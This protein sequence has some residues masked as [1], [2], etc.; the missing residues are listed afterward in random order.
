MDSDTKNIIKK[1]WSYNIFYLVGY[2]IFLIASV[3]SYITK[4]GL[5]ALIN[6]VIALIFLIIFAVNIGLAKK[7]I[8]NYRE[9]LKKHFEEVIQIKDSPQSIAL[10]F[11]IGTTIAVLPTFG[12]GPL[13]GL[14]MILI[15]KKI[16]K[17]S[18]FASF[19]I[20][21]P[22]ILALLIPL[23]YWMGDFLFGGGPIIINNLWFL[24]IFSN[25]SKRY[26]LGNLIVTIIASSLSYAIIYALADKNQEKYKK[27]IEKPLQEAIETFEEKIVKVDEKIKESVEEIGEKIKENVIENK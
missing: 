24:D 3:K 17:V 18:L 20:W 6:L 8:K 14:F 25:Y 15:F 19:I 11:A 10:G 21:N 1:F 12:F 27:L 5:W 23:E 22:V 13:I 9:K 16:S 2:T 7:S 26:L 4:S